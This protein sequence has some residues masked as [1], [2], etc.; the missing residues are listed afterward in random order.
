LIEF[1]I[2]FMLYGCIQIFISLIFNQTILKKEWKT[3]S[4]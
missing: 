3:Y 1:M 2:V 4:K